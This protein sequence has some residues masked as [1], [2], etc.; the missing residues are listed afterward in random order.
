MSATLLEAPAV[1]VQ[2]VAKFSSP[3][4]EYDL[5]TTDGTPLGRIEEQ[6]S[7]GS[8]FA[9]KLATLRFL[10]TDAAGATVG[11][12]EKPGAIGRSSFLVYDAS[13]QQVGVIEQENLFLD[14]QLTLH[15]PSGDFRL[16]SAAINAWTWTLADPA[17]TQVGG[18]SREFAGLAD[19]FTSA[20]HFVV[21]LGPQLTGPTRLVALL[22]CACLDF[23]RDERAAK[24]R[25]TFN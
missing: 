15:T 6:A 17:G 13:N 9:R 1:V 2:Q 24:R 3:R 12:I 16:T 19:V 4:E 21:Q 7:L 18:I 23:I 14:P 22:A 8:F 10:V 25:N 5:F 20:E 11:A